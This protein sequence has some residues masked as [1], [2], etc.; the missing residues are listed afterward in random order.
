MTEWHYCWH[1]ECKQK[2]TRDMFFSD[3]HDVIR[4]CKIC[5]RDFACFFATCPRGHDNR[6]FCGHCLRLIFDEKGIPYWWQ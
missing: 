4:T 1:P 6:W 5:R 3:S 2:L